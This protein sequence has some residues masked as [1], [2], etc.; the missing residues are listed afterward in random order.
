MY[1]PACDVITGYRVWVTVK[2]MPISNTMSPGPISSTL[3]DTA[4]GISVTV[5]CTV[6]ETPAVTVESLGEV[7][8]S[9]AGSVECKS[10]ELEEIS[11]AVS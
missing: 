3:S 1:W 7:V 8:T 10:R 2:L 9:G 11:N 6:W 4:N 5:H